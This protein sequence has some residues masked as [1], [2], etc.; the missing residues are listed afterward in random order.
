M[1][2]HEIRMEVFAYPEK[3]Q[4]LHGKA[5]SGLRHSHLLKPGESADDPDHMH[6]GE[7]D[8][9][10][11]DMDSDHKHSQGC[12]AAIYNIDWSLHGGIY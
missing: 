1:T 11:S 12:G 3:W 10:H 8:E 4:H 5:L 2:D 6:E 9:S 7:L